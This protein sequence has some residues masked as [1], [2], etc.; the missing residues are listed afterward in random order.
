MT[1]VLRVFVPA[2]AIAAVF[3][4]LPGTPSQAQ[5][6]KEDQFKAMAAKAAAYLKKSQNEDGSWSAAPQN[7]SGGMAS[8]HSS[9]RDSVK[10][11]S[12]SP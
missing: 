8:R 5:P 3:V 11:P 7:P 12:E 6:A 1:I 2:T 4:L 10:V 9:S